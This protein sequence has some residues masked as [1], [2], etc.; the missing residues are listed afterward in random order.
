MNAEKRKTDRHTDKWCEKCKKRI[1]GPH[2]ARHFKWHVDKG[3]GK[4]AFT[5]IP[6]VP[7]SIKQQEQGDPEPNPDKEDPPAAPNAIVA[8]GGQCEQTEKAPADP[9]RKISLNP[10]WER[11]CEDTM[12]VQSSEPRPTPYPR[13]EPYPHYVHN[14]ILLPT[15]FVNEAAGSSLPPEKAPPGRP[16]FVIPSQASL[17]RRAY[18]I[19]P[20]DPTQPP[21]PGPEAPQHREP[22][23][24]SLATHLGPES[25]GPGEPSAEQ[26]EGRHIIGDPVPPL[27]PS[28][29][30]MAGLMRGI[31]VHADPSLASGQPSVTQFER[32]QGFAEPARLGRPRKRDWS[33][34]ECL[35]CHK[36][37][38]RVDS[39]QR[40]LKKMHPGE[41]Y[42]PPSLDLLSC[43]SSPRGI[44]A[45][46]EESQT[47]PVFV[48]RKRPTPENMF[49]TWAEEDKLS[50]HASRAE[51]RKLLHRL[52]PDL[53]CGGRAEASIIKLEKIKEC[54]Q[55]GS[56]GTIT[57]ISI[58][59]GLTIH[60]ERKEIWIVG[61]VECDCPPAISKETRNLFLLVHNLHLTVKGH[62]LAS[63]SSS[64]AIVNYMFVR[65]LAHPSILIPAAVCEA[66]KSVF[67][68]FNRDPTVDD[69]RQQIL[70][71][72]GTNLR[73]YVTVNICGIPVDFPFTP[74]VQQVQI[75]E[76]VIKSCNRHEFALIESPT[77]SGKTVAFLCA[78]L[79]C[80]PYCG[81]P[82]I[83][84]A[85]RTHEQ[86]AK[87]LTELDKTTY[88][89]LAVVLGSK[90]K[91]CCAGC[92]HRGDTGNIKSMLFGI[93]EAR[94]CCK[95][96]GSCPWLMS[97]RLACHARVILLPYEYFF[98]PHYV[99]KL[100]T[101]LAHNKP[102]IVI[103][104][105]HNFLAAAE[106][107]YNVRL[108]LSDMEAAASGSEQADAIISR[109][110]HSKSMTHKGNILRDWSYIIGKK[111]LANPKQLVRKKEATEA[112]FEKGRRALLK[113][114]DVIS[115][116]SRSDFIEWTRVKLFDDPKDGRIIETICPMPDIAYKTFLELRPLS[117]FMTSGTLPLYQ[118]HKIQTF[119]P[120]LIAD[121]IVNS[122]NFCCVNIYSH[123][124][125]NKF[126]FTYKD[127]SP[128][129]YKM[130]GELLALANSVIRGG[131]LV[132]MPSYEVMTAC[133]DEWKK[134]EILHKG[135]FWE[136]SGIPG[137]VMARYKKTINDEGKAVLIAVARGNFAEGLDFADEHARV[138]V[139]VGVPYKRLNTDRMNLKREYYDS[140]ARNFDLWYDNDAAIALRQCAGRVIRHYHDFGAV[141]LVGD[142]KRIE[143]ILPEWFRPKTTNTTD[144]V[145]EVARFVEEAYRGMPGKKENNDANTESALS[146]Y[147]FDYLPQR[148][149]SK[150]AGWHE[151]KF[152][153]TL[154]KRKSITWRNKKVIKHIMRALAGRVL[155]ALIQNCGTKNKS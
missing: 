32:S 35:L 149:P 24:I 37:L 16:E 4:P 8:L 13:P 38:S 21:F 103:D 147:L 118:L 17:R 56:D 80:S 115:V 151:V 122:Q 137:D 62:L 124:N 92:K 113:L 93:N 111:A 51:R 127:R 19:Q 117:L 50:A 2:W 98:I 31:K 128:Q 94:R 102:I 123:S 70:V 145:A 48:R 142:Y 10:A 84:Y 33:T 106:D 108:R 59:R 28:S 95:H 96:N 66:L 100:D 104:E 144:G 11:K 107:T 75:A 57:Y 45:S 63:R 9:A 154:S 134:C 60:A 30:Q 47:D 110:K 114:A 5:R 90:E 130:L 22:K 78:L 55:V 119:G 138:V 73:H 97:R 71:L 88:K 39:L 133:A 41:P 77:G 126:S 44:C 101:I 76:R 140:I 53:E 132:F 49:P 89:C 143:N 65:L 146:R 29:L 129:Q 34:P 42:P 86:L 141:M 83:L 7:A 15:S 26:Y 121:Q 27:S 79:A 64:W 69:T 153:R 40:H 116:I 3:E 99:R 6:R 125:G 155:Y 85:S 74:Y 87:V 20:L 112:V 46:S 148:T 52:N 120:R 36:R 82:T 12:Q 23:V 91:M 136:N 131:V 58:C 152:T 54:F 1:A 68:E 150:D 18:E 139:I 135:V 25:P 81:G 105:A 72:R 109:L 61:D 67:Y 14:T 43:L